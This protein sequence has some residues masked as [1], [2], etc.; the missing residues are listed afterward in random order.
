MNIT[1][2]KRL[3]KFC[4]LGKVPAL[5][6][7]H[8]GVGKTA[9][10]GQTAK[11]NLPNHLFQT[12]MLSQTDIGDLIG[13]PHIKELKFKINEKGQKEIDYAINEEGEKITSWARPEWM[14]YEPVVLFLDEV[15]QATRDVE[16]ASFQLV[17]EKRIHN[18]RLHPDS[19][20]IAA[21]NPPSTEYTTANPLSSAFVK[22]F[23]VIPFE[24]TVEEVL[25]Y[26]KESGVFHPNLLAFMKFQPEH[27]GL[28]KVLDIGFKI[29]PCPRTLEMGSEIF[30][31]AE[32]LDKSNLT[33][34]EVVSD[35]LIS[36]LGREAAASYLKF[37]ESQEKPFTF[38]EV[39][40]NWE[41]SE[42]KF[43]EFR[44]KG[45][46]DLV[47]QSVNNVF[48]GILG[49]VSEIAPKVEFT[50]YVNDVDSEDS[51]LKKA[52]TIEVKA[53]FEKFIDKNKFKNLISFLR[54]LPKDYFYQFTYNYM[55]HKILQENVEVNVNIARAN[56]HQ[57][58]MLY[59]WGGV[60]K[61][62]KNLFDR[63]NSEA[64]DIDSF[65]KS[66]KSGS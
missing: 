54:T 9:V 45:R 26:G 41:T 14:P 57:L 19:T 42:I 64:D 59:L 12:I 34:I 21:I 24:P 58:V 27:I 63:V 16:S 22:R 4:M 66:Q 20:I 13:I 52:R 11:E 49:F 51:A 1:R 30:R 47:S 36:A 35:I 46:E 31:A 48:E 18:H 56:A 17:H 2:T 23:V 50:G 53:N 55:T 40:T 8:S 10:V 29:E 43:K 3:L 7:G 37:M 5:L 39:F 65:I 33:N 62:H 25:S 15:N 61:T 32:K 28:N 44:E 38:E 6:V 60:S